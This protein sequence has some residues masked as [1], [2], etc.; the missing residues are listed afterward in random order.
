MKMDD[1]MLQIGFTLLPCVSRVSHPET[2]AC[3]I[4]KA[5]DYT[6][7]TRTHICCVCHNLRKIQASS[8][9]AAPSASCIN[10]PL[11][12]VAKKVK[13]DEI[14]LLFLVLHLRLERSGLRHLSRLIWFE[15]CSAS[16]TDSLCSQGVV[17]IDCYK[18]NDAWLQTAAAFSHDTTT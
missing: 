13:T 4:L 1:K 8:C 2:D 15:W 6:E 14:H 12:I 10:N 18:W 11:D 17:V 9:N 16:F 5:L 3:R 7:Y